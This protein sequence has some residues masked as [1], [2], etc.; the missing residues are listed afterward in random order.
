MD[1]MIINEDLNIDHLVNNMD[2]DDNEDDENQDQTP[3]T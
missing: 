1:T 3:M 2:D